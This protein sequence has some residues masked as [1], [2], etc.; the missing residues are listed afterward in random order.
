MQRAVPSQSSPAEP[1]APAAPVAHEHCG[2]KLAAGLARIGMAMRHHAWA[3]RGR[4]GLTPTQSQIL[5]LLGLRGGEGLTISQ[6][7]AEMAVT[8]PTVSDA[9]AALERKRL[10]SRARSTVD[11][12]HVRVR[13]TRRGANHAAD[14]ALWPEALAQA[15]DGLDERE[16]A[17]LTRA[18]VRMIRALQGAGH[19]PV[20]RMC[21]SCV[22]FR[23]HMHAGAA[24]PHHCAFVD[25]PLGDADLQLDCPDHD[26]APLTDQVRLWSLFVE[27]QPIAEV[28]AASAPSP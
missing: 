19:I 15:I 24:K 28:S 12:R 25:A 13:L 16:Q 6:L 5:S 7:A 10:V 26:A 20:S 17:A 3:S 27:G 11:A 14:S 21:P 2:S 22:F 8:Q 1:A 18:M 9:V 4:H 23:P